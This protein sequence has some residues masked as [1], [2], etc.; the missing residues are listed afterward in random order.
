MRTAAVR[1]TGGC[2]TR[3]CVVDQEYWD[4]RVFCTVAELHSVSA[5]ARH[6]LMSQSGV[7]NVIHRLGQRY[8]HRL[9]ESV[10]SGY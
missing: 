2:R 3:M 6:R 5:A 9:I 10:V 8:G 4:L 1:E 7:S